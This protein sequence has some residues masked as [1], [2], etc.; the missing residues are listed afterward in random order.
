MLAG[1]M[2]APFTAQAAGTGPEAQCSQV[3]NDDTIRHYDPRLRLG[4][5]KAYRRLFPHASMPPDETSFEAGTHVRCMNG[6]LFACF[7]GANLA[8][9]K[10]NASAENKGAEAYCRANPQASVVPAY[11]TGHDTIYR[12]HCT[13][14]RAEITGPPIPLDDRGFAVSQWAPIK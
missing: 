3:Q 2:L 10:V 7:T 14:G 8:C 4:L 6:H 1:L 11:A 5:L 13:G 12:F 9:A